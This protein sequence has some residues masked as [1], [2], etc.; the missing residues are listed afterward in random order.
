MSKLWKRTTRSAR[1][2][3]GPTLLAVLAVLGVSAYAVYAAG[4]KPD[5]SIAASPASQTVS[6]GQATTYT[7]M[8][9][10]LNGF[11][12]SVSLAASNLPSGATASWKLSDG[13]SS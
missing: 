6:Q 5:F 4:G 13:T 8:V 9:T 11:T 3:I 7:V 12:G 1:R 10:R 2:K